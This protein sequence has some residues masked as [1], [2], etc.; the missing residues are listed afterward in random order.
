MK[1][2]GDPYWDGTTD[3]QSGDPSPP[4]APASLRRWLLV[5]VGIFGF[6]ILVGVIE[7]A[8]NG[9]FTKADCL[10]GYCSIAWD[11]EYDEEDFDGD[12]HPPRVRWVYWSL[13]VNSIYSRDE[14]SRDEYI[15]LAETTAFIGERPQ[16]IAFF[17]VRSS[18]P[19]GR[20]K[21]AFDAL[22]MRYSIPSESFVLHVLF[23]ELGA[24]GPNGR[25]PDLV[26]LTSSRVEGRYEHVL[27]SQRGGGSKKTVI[28]DPNFSSMVP[29][30]ILRYA[31][32]SVDHE[33]ELRARDYS[34]GISDNSRNESGP[35]FG[36]GSSAERLDAE[37]D[38]SQFGSRPG[39]DS[40]SRNRVVALF[41][42]NVFLGA[43]MIGLL[44]F[45]LLFVLFW[46]V[47]WRYVPVRLGQGAMR[48]GQGA[49]RAVKA[50]DGF[51]SK[52]P[53]D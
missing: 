25:E 29:D 18:Y 16:S 11:G 22:A 1:T 40:F 9:H 45:P 19:M 7:A 32:A 41:E 35:G 34:F 12:T 44:Q 14:Y 10:I 21:T 31:Q 28:E 5:G 6:S 4:V 38:K 26:T 17:S 8:V 50:A 37:S 33:R 48:L 30:K 51:L 46:I 52:A 36:P 49:I 47:R 43:F 3:D 39:F 2:I 15:A 13:R 53:K 20:R 23:E 24:A 42:R 27:E